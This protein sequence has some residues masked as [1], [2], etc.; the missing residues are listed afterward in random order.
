MK[1]IYQFVENITELKT[2]REIMQEKML[3]VGAGLVV[4]EEKELHKTSEEQEPEL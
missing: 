3:C 2:Q 4:K 1:Q